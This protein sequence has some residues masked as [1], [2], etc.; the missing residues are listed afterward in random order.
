MKKAI[1]FL[2]IVIVLLSCGCRAEK[3]KSLG[4]NIEEFQAQAVVLPEA[5]HADELLIPEKQPEVM[6]CISLEE[7]AG[8]YYYGI[9]CLQQS[10]GLDY[11]DILVQAEPFKE[12]SFQYPED[13]L[14][15]SVGS[16]K[17]A[18]MN[19]RFFING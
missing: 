11:T 18:V 6:D 9:K 16:G 12:I 7:K 19:N 17:Y 15:W 2:W 10:D 8:A 4:V 13:L 14:D 5:I 3:T 1:I